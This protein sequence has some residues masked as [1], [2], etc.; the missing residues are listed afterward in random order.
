MASENPEKSDGVPKEPQKEASKEQKGPAG[1][2]DATPVPHAPT[3]YTVKI[4]FHRATHLPIADMGKLSSD[5]YTKAELKTDLLMRHKEDPLLTFRT[6]TIWKNTEPDWEED[7][8]LANVPASGFRMKARI[9]DEDA[10]DSD[11]RLGNVHVTVNRISDSWPG[12][13]N[14]PYDVHY[15]SGSWRAYALRGLA[16]CMGKEKHMQGQLYVS[17]QVLG[18][19]EGTEGGRT[20]TIGPNHWCKHYSPLLGRIAGSKEPDNQEYHDQHDADDAKRSGQGKKQQLMGKAEAQKQSIEG[21]KNEKK[22]QSVQRYNFQANQ[23]QLTGPVPADLYHRFVEFKPFIKALFTASGVR[24]MILSKALHAQ[25]THVY[26]FNPDTRYGVLPGPG[27]DM[28]LK[29]LDLCHF[30][31]GGRIHT[32]VLTTDG[33]LRFTETGKEFGIDMLSKHTMHSDAGIYIAYS[34]EFFI[35]RV[36]RPD[37]NSPAAHVAS[38]HPPDPPA[39]D[40]QSHPPGEVAGG[41]P[42]AEAPKDPARYELVI[43][44]DS[45]TY[46]PNAKLLPQLREFLGKNFLGLK[47]VT[48]DCQKDAELMGK[49][50]EE[51]RERKKKERGERVVYTQASSSRGSVSSSDEERLE[52]LEQAPT[53]EQTHR[54]GEAVAPFTRD[55]EHLRK[56]MGERERRREGAEGGG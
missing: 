22:Q 13:Q 29:F 50:K 33:L 2:F 21:H 53:M 31:E 18:R 26:N 49:M 39:L 11:D 32:Y 8:V 7:W 10:N 16:V 23:F 14:R 17:V 37:R 1:G 42:D 19:T 6:R 54:L 25:H 3:G 30:D 55:H 44:N 52:Q 51:Q 40:N 46:R 4:T 43:D 41:P 48:L 45:G 36:R 20:Y 47:I 28:T 34:G 15:R 27:R 24:G 56:V 9:Y 5:P 35:R 12:I 38:T